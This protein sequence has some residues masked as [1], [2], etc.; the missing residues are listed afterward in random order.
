MG[1]RRGSARISW[2]ILVAVV[3]ATCVAYLPSLGNGF[4]NWD[5]PVYVT[6]NTLVM[7]PLVRN[8]GSLL[9]T[10]VSLNY[11]PLTMLSLALDRSVQGAGP[12]GF[13]LT[14]LLFHLLNTALAFRL[15]Y[16]L[17]GRRTAVAAVTG[18]LF[19]L[20]PMH[21]ESVAWISARKDVLYACFFLAGLLAW[22]R[23]RRSGRRLDYAFVFLLFLASVLAKAMAVVFPLVLILIEYLQ[24]RRLGRKLL[25]ETLPYFVVSA[26]FGVAAVA[27]Q[28]R[29][30]IS[31]VYP[32]GQRLLFA[33]YGLVM[34]A[35][36]LMVPSRL[37]AF[38]PYPPRDAPLPAVFWL[39][40]VLVLAT[41]AGVWLVRRRT[42]VPAF[43]L[44]FYLV[45]V[46]LVLQILSVGQAILADRYTYLSYF[47]L[48][49]LLGWA[50]DAAVRARLQPAPA[51]RVLAG[52]AVAGGL[53]MGVAT[54]DRIPVWSGSESLWSDVIRKFP[55]AAEAYANRGSYYGETGKVAQARADLEKAVS[56]DGTRARYLELL[57][58]AYGASGDY[59]RA[60]ELFSKGLEQDPRSP[61]L[62]LNR[63]ITYS[64]L[65]RVDDAL[66]AYQ[67]ALDYGVEDPLKV[68]VNRG[69]SYVTAGDLDLAMADADTALT[70]DPGNGPAELIRALVYRARGNAPAALD[71]ARRARNAG[72]PGAEDLI[73]KLSGS[74]PDTPQ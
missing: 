62:W 65:G 49:F 24:G 54:R 66:P 58:T 48:A 26:G 12:R 39:A 36:K 63:A 34:Y 27:I 41:A 20:H 4:T 51:G 44:G 45:T 3:A 73:R 59:D 71:H 33:C 56:L 25:L 15:A 30:A 47:G 55:N 57:G 42:R 46:I 60:L 7:G 8:L 23:Y 31:T 22:L 28:S 14:N 70:L 19:G 5:D 6:G 61:G 18:L 37:S 2:W 32:V 67:K 29:E 35:V 11:H 17:S 13:H 53:A 43:A 68:Y 9:T 50:V 40:P 16:L 10:P 52:I 21:V 72:T 1:R 69:R 38:Y 74:T 64:L